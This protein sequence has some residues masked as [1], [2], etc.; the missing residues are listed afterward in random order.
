M[1]T[2]Q[3]L[4]D[5]VTEMSSV[6]LTLQTD[7]IKVM[8]GITQLNV[9]IS[10]I[11]QYKENNMNN[12]MLINNMMNNINDNIQNIN[13]G[14]NNMIGMQYMNMPMPMNG[15]INNI[16]I[17]M[18]NFSEDVNGWNLIFEDNMYRNSIPVRISEQKSIKEAI[19]IYLLK[20]GI[21]DKCKFIFNTELLPEMKICDSGL[22]NMSKIIVICGKPVIG[23]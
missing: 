12:N 1:N 9:I 21:T 8:N 19:K 20:S 7:M 17:G 4:N 22:T 18:N 10:N 2:Q 6:L 15:M 3:N 13:M 16:N 14:M 23:G 5:I 11:K